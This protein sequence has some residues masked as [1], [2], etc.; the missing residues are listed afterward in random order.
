MEHLKLRD[1]NG[2]LI[3][4]LTDE[5][6]KE[7]KKNSRKYNPEKAKLYNAKYKERVKKWTEQ[8]KEIL[9]EKKSI[10]YQNRKEHFKELHKIYYI[11]NKEKVNNIN[12]EWVNKNKE[13]RKQ[14]S[15]N[16]TSKP[17]SKQKKLLYD[18]VYNKKDY[19]KVSKRNR[20]KKRGQIERE[21]L[22]D[23][24]VLGRIIK[25]SNLTREQ[26]KQHPELIEV[27]K[28]IIKTKRLCKTSQN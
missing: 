20:S 1:N 26:I 25:N 2:R 7:R 19:V 28:L 12:K 13:K 6:R 22:H 10:Y 16:Y 8:N 14:H 24:Y 11:E 21:E 3:S 15:A 18:E 9:K 17:E 5:E 27:Q 23:N 4:Y